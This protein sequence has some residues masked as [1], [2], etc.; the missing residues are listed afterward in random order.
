MRTLLTTE[1]DVPKRAVRML[2]ENPFFGHGLL[3]I[4]KQSR[5]LNGNGTPPA[6]CLLAP[7]PSSILT[8]AQRGNVRDVMLPCHAYVARP[9]SML[10]EPH[11]GCW[12]VRS[13]SLPLNDRRNSTQ[14]RCNESS[15]FS[16]M[17]IGA[18]RHHR[19]QPT[20]LV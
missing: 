18:L 11:S 12:K 6:S 4:I 3:G 15:R 17:S 2:P 1:D 16:E 13:K 7:A 9:L 19:A 8:F 10:T 5:K 14:R 20:I